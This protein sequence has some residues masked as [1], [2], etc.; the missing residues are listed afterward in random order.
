MGRVVF[1]SNGG[2]VGDGVRVTR[3]SDG[4]QTLEVMVDSR[5]EKFS[6]I[7]LVDDQSKRTIDTFTSSSFTQPGDHIRAEAAFHREFIADML[8]ED[9]VKYLLEVVEIGLAADREKYARIMDHIPKADRRGT[10]LLSLLWT[11][12]P[13]ILTYGY[14][15]QQIEYISGSY[16]DEL[17]INGG[18]KRLR[19]ALEQTDHP[20]TINNHYAVGYNLSVP[21]DWVAP[22]EK[23]T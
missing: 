15:S 13:R 9:A 14:I 4:G 1:A 6:R 20:I 10:Q 7:I 18:I 11:S 12:R 21:D 19:R 22:W 17:A 2:T 3:V 23:E 16:P 5:A 8:P